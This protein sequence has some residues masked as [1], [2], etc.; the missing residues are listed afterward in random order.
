MGKKD[1]VSTGRV[2][3]EREEI[4][5]RRKEKMREKRE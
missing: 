3:A 5:S 2:V 1:R 4:K